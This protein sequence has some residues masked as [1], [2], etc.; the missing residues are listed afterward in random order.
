MWLSR[1]QVKILR[2]LKSEEVTSSDLS[3]FHDQST[4]RTRGQYYIQLRIQTPPR[5]SPTSLWRKDMLRCKC[6]ENVEVFQLLEYSLSARR[7]V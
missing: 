4:N 3:S 7:G 2:N 1:I 5:S 6:H